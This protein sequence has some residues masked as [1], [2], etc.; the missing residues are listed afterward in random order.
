MSVMGQGL[1][2]RRNNLFK[3]D[4]TSSSPDTSVKSYSSTPAIRR[5]TTVGLTPV[6][7][8][9]KKKNK[10]ANGMEL[11]LQATP[12]SAC[13]NASEQRDSEGNNF[14]SNSAK[15]LSIRLPSK[16]KKNNNRLFR[17][18]SVHIPVELSTSRES[19]KNDVGSNRLPKLQ[20]RDCPGVHREYSDSL[21]ISSIGFRRQDKLPPIN[22]H[23]ERN[24]EN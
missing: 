10:A 18:N 15:A 19:S 24:T 20:L 2:L 6:S 9:E 11:S 4:I 13:S 17:H 7:S 16:I 21:S 3:D 1:D 5:G 14:S 22:G 8:G 12:I 23:L